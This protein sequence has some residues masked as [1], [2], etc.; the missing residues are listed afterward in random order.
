MWDVDNV[1]GIKLLLLF[2]HLFV[3]SSQNKIALKYVQNYTNFSTQ[4]D[5]K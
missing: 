5:T 1:F 3:C 2:I 4:N